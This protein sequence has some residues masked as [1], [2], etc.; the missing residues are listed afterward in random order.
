MTP[1]D[2]SRAALPENIRKTLEAS[3]LPVEVAT[4][5][6]DYIAELAFERDTL[7]VRPE[8]A[9]TMPSEDEIRLASGEMTAQEMRTVKAVLGWYIRRCQP[10][11]KE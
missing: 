1:L 9:L 6:A 8:V 11:G 5:I 3:D 10:Q 2:R 4:A 7:S